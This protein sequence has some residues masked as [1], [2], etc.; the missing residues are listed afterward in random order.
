MRGGGGRGSGCA[1]PP[2]LFRLEVEVNDAVG[3]KEAQRV[4]EL[5]GEVPGVPLVVVVPL[6]DPLQQLAALRDLPV[7]TPAVG[8]GCRRVW[9][10]AKGGGG[11]RRRGTGG[12]GEGGDGGKP[13]L[14][15]EGVEL[16]VLVETVDTH[17]VGVV[18]RLQNTHFLEQ[19][20]SVFVSHD[21]KLVDVLDRADL[22]SLFMDSSVDYGKRAATQFLA[23]GGGFTV[24]PA[25]SYP[26]PSRVAPNSRAELTS[27]NSQSSVTFLGSASGAP[28]PSGSSMYGWLFSSN[29]ST[30]GTTLDSL[31]PMIFGDHH[32]HAR[33]SS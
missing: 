12:R 22:P 9:R 13:Y 7:S 8:Q 23:G 20:L 1:S 15:G 25:T 27:L 28:L 30:S 17:D 26:P 33:A 11:G 2:A 31:V 16:V 32:P 24:S 4:D 19:V 3:M 18:D 6:H 10:R 5:S 14:G 21:V 29:T